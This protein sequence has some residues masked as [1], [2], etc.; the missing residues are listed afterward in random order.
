MCSFRFIL[1]GLHAVLST[2]GLTTFEYF[3]PP[4]HKAQRSRSASA[5]SGD[6]AEADALT[7][8]PPPLAFAGPQAPGCWS[9]VS[10][11]ACFLS[12]S[13]LLRVLATPRPPSLVAG[14]QPVV[15][16]AV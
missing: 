14:G 13:G 10:G 1:S 16:D 4:A 11:A 9:W 15:A 7:S 3:H 8:M 12:V 6:D 2:H 5:V